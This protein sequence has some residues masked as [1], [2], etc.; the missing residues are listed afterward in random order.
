MRRI[1]ILYKI[2]WETENYGMEIRLSCLRRNGSRHL[3]EQISTGYGWVQI[4]WRAVKRQKMEDIFWNPM[5][6]LIILDIHSHLYRNGEK[7]SNDFW[8]RRRIFLL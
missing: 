7:P 6:D 2:K 8:R 1:K 3:R 5:Q 4:A